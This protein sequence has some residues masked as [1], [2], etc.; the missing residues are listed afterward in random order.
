MTP[1]VLLASLR[2]PV[3]LQDSPEGPRLLPSPGGVASGLGAV[4]DPQ[5]MRWFGWAGGPTGPEATAALQQASYE[6]VPISEEELDAFYHG[7][8]NAVLWPVL[9]QQIA[10]L[11][12]VIEGF[13]AYEAV[14]RRFAERL[15]AAWEPGT[16]IWIHDYQLLRVAALL[17]E[18]RPDAAI[19][20]FLH[21]PAPPPESW[22]ILPQRALLLEGLLAC[23]LVGVHTAAFADHLAEAAEQFVEA[24]VRLDR[25]H[26]RGRVTRL[27]VRPLGLDPALFVEPEEPPFR[28]NERLLLAIDRLDYTKGVPRRL[29]AFERL[30]ATHPEWHGRVHLLQLAVPTRDGTRAYRRF[31]EEVEAEV[32]RINGRFAQPDWTP[33]RYVRRSLRREAL[34]D[35][36]RQADV[37]IVTPIRDGLNLV[38][39]EYC[40]ARID[41]DGVLV[42]SEFAGV[43]DELGDA[44]V[45]NPYDITAFADALHQALLMPDTER[46]RRMASLRAQVFA[47]DGAAWAAG[48]LAALADRPAPPAAVPVS[49]PVELLPA[50]RRV[51]RLLLLL[52]YDGTLVP[53]AAHPDAAA[54]DETV[55]RLLRLLAGRRGTDV[56]LV[57]GRPRAVLDRWFGEL[58]IGLHAEHGAWSRRAPSAPWHGRAPSADRWFAVVRAAL[59]RAA[60]A[61][62]GSH[63]EVKQS[64]LAWHWR[65]ADPDTATRHRRTLRQH[66]RRLLTDE[67]AAL[68]IG[69]HVLEVR[70]A[71]ITKG[72]VAAELAASAPRGTL[73]VAAGDDVTDD[74]LFA[75]LPESAVTIAVGPRPQLARYR[76]AGPGELRALLEGLLH[77]TPPALARSAR[78][79]RSSRP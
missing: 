25:L 20:F 65:G 8:A 71:G 79:P 55:L 23:D 56:H 19:G 43:A 28:S 74:E 61:T 70:P 24:E 21:V 59:E 53:I 11:P 45:I 41:G 31:R 46:H 17:R 67:P 57:S 42:L 5:T 12:L 50:I 48:F 7:Y 62:P 2:L 38:A 30:L 15:A 76:F 68:L 54:P 10:R 78:R 27:L 60:Q 73:L 47:S 36:Y 4:F 33:I 18:L 29:L 32:S 22:A 63:V 34:R 1:R 6:P 64:V 69:D 52:D 44:V 51:G 9:H 13:D 75:A 26:W 39:K 49:S 66:L 72:R 3:A 77:A 14:N 35:L 16:L 40:A 58:P 37:M